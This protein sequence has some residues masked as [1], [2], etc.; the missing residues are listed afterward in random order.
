MSPEPD[1][2]I[3][4]AVAAGQAAAE[5]GQAAKVAPIKVHTSRLTVQK[6]ADYVTRVDGTVYQRFTGEVLEDPKMQDH[7]SEPR[8]TFGTCGAPHHEAI[9]L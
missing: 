3:A 5:R 8:N 2:A 1:P 7:V 4:R 6:A 9:E